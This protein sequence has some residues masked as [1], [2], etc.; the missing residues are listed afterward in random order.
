[1]KFQRLQW[2]IALCSIIL[3]ST[4]CSQDSKKQPA[5]QEAND[6]E[7]NKIKEPDSS[8]IKRIGSTIIL[9]E[10]AINYD[11]PTFAQFKEG[12]SFELTNYV[13]DF[14]TNDMAE[15]VHK[16]MEAI[17]LHD[18][19]KFKENMFDESTV[20]ASMN[21]FD[22][23]YTDGV[24]FEFKELNGITYDEVAK[25]IQVIVTFVRNTNDKEIEKE[26]MTYSLL[27]EKS[28]GQWLIAH[29][30]GN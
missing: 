15:K 4:G 18:E 14:F 12:V 25:R 30:D 22:Y 24:K 10:K 5:N 23:K 9:Y 3:A 29:M 6:V 19:T 1:M 16:N 13:M 28:K 26:I 11:K 8:D 21:W 27:K 7:T 2:T 17:V 20:K